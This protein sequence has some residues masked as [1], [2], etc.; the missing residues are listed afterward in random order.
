MKPNKSPPSNANAGK[1]L[2]VG[3]IAWRIVTGVV[4][5]LLF[6]VVALW[7][8]MYFVLHGSWAADWIR[9]RLPAGMQLEAFRIGPWPFDVRVS[10]VAW[11]GE[12][13]EAG[14]G[15]IAATA[16]LFPTG[17]SE[18]SADLATLVIQVDK[19]PGADGQSKPPKPFSLA[20]IPSGEL[21]FI[22]AFEGTVGVLRIEGA[23][24]AVHADAVRVSRER[25]RDG[26]DGAEI[27]ARRCEVSDLVNSRGWG[28]RD[29]RF[30]ITAEPN[31]PR[32]R[33]E[34]AL[35]DDSGS[36]IQL[37]L[38]VFGRDGREYAELAADISLSEAVLPAEP[39]TGVVAGPVELQGF[40]IGPVPLSGEVG[41]IEVAWQRLSAGGLATRHVRL[42]DMTIGPTTI[43]VTPDGLLTRLAVAMEGLATTRLELFDIILSHP[44]IARFTIDIDRRAEGTLEGAAFDAW[45]SGATRLGAGAGDLVWSA[46]LTGGSVRGTVALA[47]GVLGGAIA[48]KRSPLGKRWSVE[49]SFDGRDIGNAL[50]AAL[51]GGGVDGIETEAR[52]AIDGAIV[53]IE[54]GD[55]GESTELVL[56]AMTVRHRERSFVWDGLGWGDP[57][58]ATTP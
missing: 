15:A 30:T 51:T 8:V 34:A 12:G 23:A 3:A 41:T 36:R 13:V 57:A 50:L 22:G 43:S 44:R 9:T 47:E 1:R 48:F 2:G 46:G 54:R 35:F 53:A 4:A 10:G 21:P 40:R 33:V 39:K 31:V 6:S 58:A 37:Q 49:G 29:C 38:Q 14:P 27:V 5:P 25:G 55:D 16:S 11:R 20:D 45:E 26:L 42:G 56:D 7:L 52:V 32:Y 18:V 19:P 24:F 28:G 17:I